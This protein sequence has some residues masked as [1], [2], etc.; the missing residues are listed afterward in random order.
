AAALSWKIGL[1]TVPYAIA[2]LFL[3]DHIAGKR[4]RFIVVTAICML[5]EAIGLLLFHTS[6]TQYVV[7][8]AAAGVALTLL[9]APWRRGP[10]PIDAA[11]APVTIGAVPNDRRGAD[12][13]GGAARRVSELAADSESG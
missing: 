3:F 2:D 6:P 1:A 12:D 13:G 4:S 9:L 5:L 7:I 8:I 10:R 11:H